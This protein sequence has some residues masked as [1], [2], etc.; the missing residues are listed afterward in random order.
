MFLLFSVT[1]PTQGRPVNLT[2]ENYA[3]VTEGKTLMV[4]FYVVEL[5]RY[6]TSYGTLT[7]FNC[8]SILQPTAANVTFFFHQINLL[9]L[10]VN[11]SQIS[12][13]SCHEIEKM[14]FRLV[15]ISYFC[16]NQP[17]ILYNYCYL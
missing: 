8:E 3:E 16:M 11:F 2:P 9:Y 10:L 17:S 13:T 5:R 1:F 4:R 12:C 7:T 14:W 6:D 15:C